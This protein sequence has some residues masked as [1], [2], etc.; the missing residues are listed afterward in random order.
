VPPP[1][2]SGV[3]GS[4]TFLLIP[5]STA[6]RVMAFDPT[7]GDLVN[8][9]LVPADTTNLSTPKAAILH[10]GG[11][12]ILV[13]DQLD[14][15]VQRYASTGFVGAFAP[16]GGVNNAI[17]DN[18]TGLT[19]HPN[20]N[21][22]VCV[23]SGANGNSVASFDASGNHSGNFIAIG[24]GGLA[25]PFDI[26][27]RASDVLVSSINTDSILRYDRTTGAFLDVFA[28]INNFPQQLFEASNGNILV[29]NFGGTQEG[30][31]E[32]TSTG[33]LVAVYDTATLGGYRGVYELPNGN[34]LVTTG[35]G[36]FEISR[37]NALIS[38]KMTGVSGQYIELA[39]GVFPVE[40]ETFSIE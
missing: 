25:G 31:V 34:L 29:A 7:T 20:G 28:T 6:D 26:L 13:S 18:I 15:L 23:Q 1:A 16:A 8:A 24:S 3:R 21:L 4:S 39:T 12:D 36:V 37:A 38:T 2:A 22:L 17:L 11:D 32:L 9:N 5:D 10:A 40:L 27:I 14:D 30:I 33:T 19:Y 35:S